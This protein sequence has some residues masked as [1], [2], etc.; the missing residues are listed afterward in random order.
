MVWNFVNSLAIASRRRLVATAIV[1][2]LSLAIRFTSATGEEV[3]IPA[4][5]LQRINPVVSITTGDDAQ[6]PHAD[7][8]PNSAQVRVPSSRLDCAVT[9]RE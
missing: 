2:G 6:L 3:E 5:S 7:W 9:A 8:G 4:Q 1:Y